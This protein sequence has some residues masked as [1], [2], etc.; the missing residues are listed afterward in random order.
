MNMAAKL[1]TA[2]LF[3]FRFVSQ[4]I[5]RT[6]TKRRRLFP[7]HTAV[8][9]WTRSG[10]V[11]IH[12][13]TFCYVYVCDFL[14]GHRALVSM[15]TYNKQQI[16][17]CRKTINQPMSTLHIEPQNGTFSYILMVAAFGSIVPMR[18]HILRR[19]PPVAWC[20][21]VRPTALNIRG[22]QRRASKSFVIKSALSHQVFIFS[23]K[24]LDLLFSLI[25]AIFYHILFESV[26][27]KK[28][29]M[30]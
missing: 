9:F 24:L 12:S 5:R 6:F 19:L 2:Q 8:S 25:S 7:V 23:G 10:T 26:R 15:P 16:A 29:S 14:S 18:V 20:Y 22:L 3:T 17:N 28:P 4:N 27:R 30:T 21:L 1:N 11:W 13:A